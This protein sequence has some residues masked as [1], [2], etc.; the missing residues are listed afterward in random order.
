MDNDHLTAHYYLVFMQETLVIS[1]ICFLFGF[2]GPF[3]LLPIWYLKSHYNGNVV[4]T[5]TI[6]LPFICYY[7]LNGHN[8]SNIEI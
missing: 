5:A 3:L 2:G 4:Q 7:Y 8:M 1:L 6:V